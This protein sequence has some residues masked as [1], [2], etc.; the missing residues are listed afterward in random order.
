MALNGYR[1]KEDK[2]SRL[3][4]TDW[5]LV[6]LFRKSEGEY[7]I[8]KDGVLLGGVKKLTKVWMVDGTQICPR[9]RKEAINEAI[10][11]FY[12]RERQK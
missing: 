8:Y 6:C 5:G 3:V 10:T 1:S 12:R 2:A 11:M 4:E 7:E 9:T